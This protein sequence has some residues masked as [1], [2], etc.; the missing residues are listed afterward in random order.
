M[1]ASQSQGQGKETDYRLII[2]GGGT[3]GHLFP[4]I[5]LAQV[6]RDRNQNNRVLFVSRGNEFEKSALQA[7]G[8]PLKSIPVEGIKG[9]KRWSQ[10][11]SMLKLPLA[12]LKSVWITWRFGPHLVIGVGSY[13]AGPVILA[14]WLLRKPIA[15]HEQNQLP[16][17]T[18]RLVAR[19]AD[20]IFVSFESSKK[21]FDTDKVCFSGNPVRKE[22]LDLASAPHNENRPKQDFEVLIVGGSQGAHAINEAVIDMLEHLE[23]RS[24]FRFV[25]QTGAADE[26]SVREAYQTREMEAIVKPFFNDMAQRYAAANLVVCR[27]GATTVAE[28]TA[29]GK[30]VIFIPFPFA[31]DNHQ[32]LNARTLAEAGAAEMIEQKDL[33]G[34]LLAE[35]INYYSAQPDRLQKMAANAKK[36]GKPDAAET[37]VDGCYEVIE[38]RWPVCP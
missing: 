32:V 20:R 18:N 5:S 29:I 33:D 21:R 3:G 12:V 11:R 10:L 16:G 9:R 22:I 4:G 27:A 19:F 8:F 34:K 25:H 1:A 36:F 2:A 14:A 7:A 13:A 17:V 26:P 35:K 37:I 23:N 38:K 24:D 30:G 28:L 6:F 31:A 15:L